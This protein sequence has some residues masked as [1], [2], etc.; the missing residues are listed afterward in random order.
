MANP[1]TS[2]ADRQAAIAEL[3]RI[4][5]LQGSKLTNTDLQAL[6]PGSRPDRKPPSAYGKKAG[7]IPRSKTIE[8]VTATTRARGARIDFADN[9]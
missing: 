3:D 5:P 2:K 8:W 7:F 9:H 1:R 6:K 4:A